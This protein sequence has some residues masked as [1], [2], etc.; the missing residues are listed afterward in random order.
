MALD[1]PRVDTERKWQAM[2][3]RAPAWLGLVFVILMVLAISVMSGVPADTRDVSG[4]W[5]VLS[6]AQRGGAIIEL[7]G[8][9]AHQ[10]Y[11]GNARVLLEREVTSSGGPEALWIDTP[12]YAAR[13]LW[14]G[15][16]ISRSGDPDRDGHANRTSESLFVQL[17]P[18]EAGTIHRL[19][20]DI[21]GDYGKGGVV[22]RMLVGPT[23][24]IHSAAS[25]LEVERLSLALGL[26]L[27]AFLPLAIATRSRRSAYIYYG[28]FATSL[29][30]MS[31]AQSNHVYEILPQAIDNLRLQRLVLGPLAP[32]M[33]AFLASYVYGAP[34]KPEKYFLVVGVTLAILGVVIPAD[35][36]YAVETVAD[37]T[38][39]IGIPWYAVL[40]WQAARS[41]DRANVGFL[42]LTFLP[43]A[44][45]A[46][47][48]IS[49]THGMRGGSSH[50]F[51]SS[52]LFVG[53]CGVALLLK[54][55]QAAERHA[56]LVE[57]SVDAMVC[58]G[59]EGTL[60]DL[61]PAA[62][63]MLGD[64]AFGRN[65]LE[66]VVDE[67]RPLARAHMSRSNLAYDR[68]E[69]RLGLDEELVVES[70]ATPMR[71]QMVLLVLRDV[72]QRR[73]IDQGMLHA[74]R[75]ET[76]GILL[77]G[78]AHDFNNMLGTL[79]AHV[80]FLQATLA[81]E[82]ALQRV[83]RM[84]S[85]IARASQ[86][87]RRLLTVAR[88]TGADLGPVDILRVCQGAVELVVPTLSTGVTLEVD[89]PEGL[90]PA[91]ADAGDLEQ[92]LVNLMV[93]A[94]DAVDG[95]GNI[96]LVAREFQVGPGG[97]GVALM[98]EDNGPGVPEAMRVE[99]F[100]PFVTTKRQGTGLGLAV[101]S[102][103]LQDHHG[104]IWHEPRPQGG[105]RIL[106]ALRHADTVHEAPAPLPDGRKVMLVED[107]KVLLEDFSKA[108][109]LAGY[110]VTSFSSPIDAAGHLEEDKPD[111]VV[112]D[113]VMEG[114]NG[115]ILAA[116]CQARYPDVPILVV[117]GFIPEIDIP[118]LEN[119]TWHLLHKPVRSARLVSVVGKL[120]RRAERAQ[121]GEL[122]I[123]RVSYLFPPLEDL[124][125][126][127]LGMNRPAAVRSGDIRSAD[128]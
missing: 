106:L 95:E 117:S 103:I 81:D 79:L 124:S 93:N 105:A 55:A 104:R 109:A 25:T 77:G 73:K 125:S 76:V 72:T 67:D 49:L 114:L 118:E 24:S 41:Y 75:M 100:R 15:V 28:L 4:P 88:G 127:S 65:I 2:L 43:I 47:S 94:R 112:T 119:G 60:I 96:R 92:V 69:F 66:W 115:L 36:L 128:R 1:Q 6:P 86:L 32:L 48:E 83:D 39:L 51:A 29:A 45:G 120:R 16:E 113:V 70:L 3:E 98:V 11:D 26:C 52:L 64:G 21:R 107:E 7:P 123:T 12:M 37:M 30:A 17:P 82:T 102:Q 63:R 121:R 44:Y 90:P 101:A 97:R 14:D 110:A 10:G 68:A 22:G 13:V 111:I 74:A 116:R 80:G 87:T 54:D 9:F 8:L 42:F 59:P 108:L 57:G 46:V 38:L 27:L 71:P 34:R 40:I 53:G 89:V 85:T 56:R 99:M 91:H 78:I 84:E 122:D 50:L 18:A 58:I 19:G 5:T 20:L 35:G 62:E 33:L 23:A 61:N 126:N 31:Y